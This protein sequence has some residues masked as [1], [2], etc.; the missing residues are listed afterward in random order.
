VAEMNPKLR[1]RMQKGAA[2]LMEAD[3]T[4]VCGVSNLTMPVAVYLAGGGV[5]GLPYV[6]SHTSMAVVTERNVY[7]FKTGMTVNAKRLL[8]K[9]PLGSVQAQFAGNGSPGR[10]LT[11]GEHKLWLAV[12]AK[13]HDL[14]RT[15]A[16]RASGAVE[17]PTPS[18]ATSPP[19]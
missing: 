9:A 8:L 15:I 2:P 3:E 6:L 16:A 13:I 4:V 11:I 18:A 14:A 5:L 19:A 1:D 7:V 17:A 10:H 12:N